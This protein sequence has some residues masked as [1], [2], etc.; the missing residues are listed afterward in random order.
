MVPLYPDATLNGELV[1]LHAGGIRE[2]AIQS[3]RDKWM[4]ESEKLALEYQSENGYG[5]P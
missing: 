5:I 1:H 4:L 3:I 2:I